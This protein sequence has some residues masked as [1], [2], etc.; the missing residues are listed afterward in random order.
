MPSP[1][2][3]L[4][5]GINVDNRTATQQFVKFQ[6]GMMKE[7][8]R[9][10][11]AVENMGKAN[12]EVST[13][14]RRDA[15]DWAS[16]IG[17]LGKYYQEEITKINALQTALDKAERARQEGDKGSQ[18]AAEKRAKA[19]KHELDERKKALKA[20]AVTTT[21]DKEQMGKDAT[22]ALGRAADSFKGTLSSFFSK[23]LKGVIL[24]G[25]GIAKH[26]AKAAAKGLA[27]GGDKL[28]GMGSAMGGQGSAMG[29]LGKGL[30]GLG[31]MGRT[32]GP[33]IGTLAKIGPVLSIVGAGIAGLVKLFIDAE[34]Q[35]K[36][37]QKSVL[38]SAS[39]TEYLAAAGGDADLAY[40]DLAEDMKKVRDAAFSLDNSDWGI[41][42]KEHLTVLNALNQQGMSL[43]GMRNEAD[44][45]KQDLGEYTAQ[46]TQV[47][48]AYARHFGLPLQEISQFQGELLSE[49]GMGLKDSQLAF[50]QMTR[51]A[52]ESGIAANKF[53][54]IIRGV[55]QDLS[56][57][58]VRMGSAIKMLKTLGKVMNAR[59][60]QRF[61]QSITQTMKNMGQDERLKVALLAG[62]KGK[63]IVEKD[64][65]NRRTNL[66]E[67][68]KKAIGISVEEVEKRLSDPKAAKDLWKEV[69]EKMKGESGRAGA[70][71]EEALELKID[72]TANKKGVYGQAFAMENL[73][74]GATVDM[75]KAAF[76]G[77]G[78]LTSRAGELGMTKFAELVGVSTQQLRGFMK[79]EVAVKEQ[80]EAMMA[81]AKTSD[82]RTRIAAMSTQ[83]ILDN[84]SEEE[85]K[86]LKD[87]TKSQLD[88]AKEQS[89][90]TNTLVEKL[91]VLI[92]FLMNELY[93]VLIDIW[94]TLSDIPGLG[95]DS[96]AR[97]AKIAAARAG[98]G[99]GSE[100]AREVATAMAKAG[101]GGTNVREAVGQTKVFQR[102][103]TALTN[104]MD[105]GAA[106]NTRELADQ[107]EAKLREG[108]RNEEESKNWE[109]I[110]NSLNAQVE[111]LRKIAAVEESSTKERD[112]AE[113]I[114]NAQIA[115]QEGGGQ[116]S[117]GKAV[118]AVMGQDPDTAKKVR[119]MQESMAGGNS[120]SAALEQ[121]GF[122]P[123]VMG[124]IMAK[125][126]HW[127]T[128]NQQLAGGAAEFEAAMKEQDEAAKKAAE[129]ASKTSEATDK[130]A[131]ATKSLEDEGV[132]KKSSIYVRFGDSF[133]KGKYQD[134]I[135]DGVLKALRRALFEYYMY[136]GL[137]RESVIKTL[138]SGNMSIEDFAN[139]MGRVSE[140]GK[141]PEDVYNDLGVAQG[142]T[143]TTGGKQ[144]GGI[145]SRISNEGM[146]IFRTPPGEG[147][148][149][150]RAGERIVPAYAG[151][152]GG[153]GGGGGGGTTHVIVSVSPDAQKLIQTEVRHGIYEHERRKRTAE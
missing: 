66:Y 50:S 26:L 106:Q 80:K 19:L 25:G 78:D 16:A 119:A 89:E 9:V 11:K 14:A 126:M 56:L 39:T 45:A 140:T 105:S 111:N 98:G 40:A 102:M 120:F 148:T 21:F 100:V 94:D 4:T 18:E 53:F 49:M 123:E 46:L 151:G 63:G 42:S 13:Q 57:Y 47:S 133:L 52:S 93:N 36:E 32:L 83:D 30:K 59:N 24:G 70:L 122:N 143:K 75:M 145:V 118:Y 137:D 117:A 41:S 112:I 69:E 87:E 68:I 27:A 90:L 96:E 71:R 72:T 6:K 7:L 139:E 141:L 37:F 73:G 55:S 108:P 110:S 22:D 35:A 136:S 149:A 88:F 127:F 8:G 82:E 153:T 97:K 38:D 10:T 91:Q 128:S 33:L 103:L 107:F 134:A 20:K 81:A 28:T 23:D 125:A 64:L 131:G 85:Q 12:S 129:E 84:L 60:A 114:L 2:E 135:H 101:E 132:K 86:A 142:K 3:V 67:D 150:I 152:G 29:A 54:S 58:N 109:S 51:S 130:T 115:K 48:V 146:A 15:D 62:G 77:G 95:G 116:I 61:M 34:S 99:M 17:D 92:D 147:V 74:M 124:K 79:L 5:I 1:D 31:S 121:A 144:H 76:A 43:K 65:E 44:L 104:S 138:Q 113:H